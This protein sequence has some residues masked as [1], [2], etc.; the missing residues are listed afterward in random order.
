L[1][2]LKKIDEANL[3]WHALR[4][5]FLHVRS[6]CR[7]FVSDHVRPEVE[8][9]QTILCTIGVDEKQHAAVPGKA[10]DVFGLALPRCELV[11]E[12]LSGQIR[13]FEH[14]PATRCGFMNMDGDV[15]FGGA[16]RARDLLASPPSLYNLV[17]IL[18]VA[19][20][21][22]EDQL[23]FNLARVDKVP[24]RGKERGLPRSGEAEDRM[25]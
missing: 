5:P 15:R 1:Q 4:R 7:F 11:L 16:R 20:E 17:E 19:D 12:R 8:V 23:R 3:L 14:Y 18:V 13:K 9:R 6:R 24:Q 21:L 22:V 10:L 25:I 2:E